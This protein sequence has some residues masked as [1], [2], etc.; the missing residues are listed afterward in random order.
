M[1]DSS[2]NP[3]PGDTL[4]HAI[5]ADQSNRLT[6]LDQHEPLQDINLALFNASV[7]PHGMLMSK[8]FGNF[9]CLEGHVT[10]FF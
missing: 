4:S 1:S 9:E 10:S 8:C 5:D 3:L 2:I 7:L 6:F